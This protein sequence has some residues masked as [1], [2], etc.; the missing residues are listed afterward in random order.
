VT[1]ETA[2]SVSNDG[3]CSCLGWPMGATCLTLPL[4][5]LTWARSAALTN[6]ACQVAGQRLELGRA[7]LAWL[8]SSRPAASAN[9]AGVQRVGGA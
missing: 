7:V 8:N 4:C 6:L 2:D 9:A 3:T 1:P 5:A